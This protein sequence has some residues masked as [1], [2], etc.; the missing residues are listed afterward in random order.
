M[1]EVYDLSVENEH[2]FFANGILVH[3]CVDAVRYALDGY[4]RDDDNIDT[5]AKIARLN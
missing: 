5:Y 2:E 1:A 3:N 4:I